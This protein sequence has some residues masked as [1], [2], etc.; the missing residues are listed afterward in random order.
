MEGPQQGRALDSATETMWEGARWWGMT[1]WSAEWFTPHEWS[2]P[3]DTKDSLVSKLPSSLKLTFSADAAGNKDST[4]V[5]RGLLEAANSAAAKLSQVAAFARRGFP[6][7]CTWVWEVEDWSVCVDEEN[8]DENGWQYSRRWSQLSE[9]REGGRSSMRKT[10]VVRR[11]KLTRRRL[12]V[13]P[14]EKGGAR[15]PPAQAVAD[16]PADL[17]PEPDAV[18]EPEPNHTR[19]PAQQGDRLASGLGSLSAM[20]SLAS[21]F[22]PLVNLEPVPT[23]MEAMADI[24]GAGVIPDVMAEAKVTFQAAQEQKKYGKLKN[25]PLSIDG[26]AFIMKYSAEDTQPPLYKDLNAKACAKDRA[27]IDPYGKYVVGTLYHMK[28]IEPYAGGEDVHR[29]VKADL[30]ADYVKGR[31]FTWHGF[32]STTKSL[33]VLSNPMFL[34]TSGKRTI[35]SISLTQGQVCIHPLSFG[36]FDVAH[37]D[38]RLDLRRPVTSPLTH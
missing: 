1:G 24:D 19:R 8:T 4:L 32:C 30:R 31:E 15:L 17:E 34:G 6:P 37:S 38:F 26:I 23:F 28:N 9:P 13:P 25:H 33:E 35:F 16:P 5:E 36:N 2:P 10:D 21:R 7:G 27:N 20:G 18:L 3:P 12:L 14:D 11:R 22:R 29:G